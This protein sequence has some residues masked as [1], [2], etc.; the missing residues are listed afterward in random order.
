[1]KF[2]FSHVDKCQLRCILLLLRCPHMCV[3]MR[4]H[5][6]LLRISEGD[7]FKF[8]SLVSVGASLLLRGKTAIFQV[9]V[10]YCLKMGKKDKKRS[11]SSSGDSRK[12][13]KSKASSKKSPPAH[14]VSQIGLVTPIPPDYGELRFTLYRSR[15][16]C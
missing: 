12:S 10:I 15:C 6:K 5:K 11:R 1:M 3:T 13:K 7:N 4:V 14:L 8:K 16:P 2:Q 9:C